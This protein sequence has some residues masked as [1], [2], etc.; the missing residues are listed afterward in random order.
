M[1]KAEGDRMGRCDKELAAFNTD[2]S[3]KGV[4]SW[5]PSFD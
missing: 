2:V 3:Q 4:S 1:L 5:L